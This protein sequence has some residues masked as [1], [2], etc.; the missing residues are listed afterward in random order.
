MILH[1]FKL[2]WNQKRKF[3]YILIE[4]FALYVMLVLCFAYIG[5][6]FYRY[7]QKA[8]YDW[9]NVVSLGFEKIETGADTLDFN[10]E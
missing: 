6:M 2:F 5:Q 1:S 4:V 7:S 10:Q 9:H 3:T 8:G